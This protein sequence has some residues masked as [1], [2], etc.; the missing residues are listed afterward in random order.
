MARNYSISTEK[1]ISKAGGFAGVNWYQHGWSSQAKQ[2]CTLLYLG[3]LSCTHLDFRE[4]QGPLK[5][6]AQSY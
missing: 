5:M 2:L 1:H 4:V 3:L 6:V